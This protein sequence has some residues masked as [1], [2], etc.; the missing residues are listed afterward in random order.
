MSRIRDK[1]LVYLA[2]R[3]VFLFH[4]KLAPYDL[5]RFLI[6]FGSSITYLNPILSQY[7][8]ASSFEPN[9]GCRLEIGSPL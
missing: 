5:I 9:S 7:M 4:E 2:V 3:R 6:L 8:T 1:G